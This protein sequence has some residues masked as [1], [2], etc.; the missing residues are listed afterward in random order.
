MHGK[1]V[2]DTTY[3]LPFFGV[4]VR[5]LEAD[6]V[7]KLRNELGAELLYPE[8]LLPEL[9]A[10][11]AKEMAKRKLRRLPQQASEALIALLL[12]VDI[13]LV[14]PKKEHIETAIKLKALGHPDIFDCILYATALY[15]DAVL[16]TR[17]REL[18]KFLESHGLETDVIIIK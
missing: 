12:E 11:I 16:V 1:A 8:L 5:G 4:R 18:I 9:A 15:E 10:R 7:L 14:R 17:D 13:S 6:T 2:L 3:L